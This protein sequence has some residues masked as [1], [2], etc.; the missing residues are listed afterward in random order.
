MCLHVCVCIH[1]VHIV[2]Y[3]CNIGVTVK[4]MGDAAPQES[5]LGKKVGCATQRA[6]RELINRNGG[7]LD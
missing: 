3:Q 1:S 2:S 6:E 4:K 7:L 5:S